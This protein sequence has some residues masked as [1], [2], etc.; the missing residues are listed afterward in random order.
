MYEKLKSFLRDEA[1]FMVVL[2]LLV[3]VVSFG[4]GRQSVISETA[5]SVSHE[6]AGVI[7]IEPE[8]IEKDPV[9]SVNSTEPAGVKVVAS[10]AGSRYHLLT[11]P[12]AGQI[13]EENKV[14]FDSISL[15]RAAG[16]TAAANCPE[17]Q[18]L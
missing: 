3:G 11:C 6:G 8:R 15:A 14:Y 12:G 2:L 17:L 1:S 18:D 9:I 16:Y 5:E 4:L 13:K 10:R 7:F